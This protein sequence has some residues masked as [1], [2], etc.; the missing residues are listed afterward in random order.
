MDLLSLEDG[1]TVQILT[2]LVDARNCAT[3]LD[4]EE[5]NG[6]RKHLKRLVEKLPSGTPEYRVLYV[7]NVAH[8]SER[9]P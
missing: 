4:L 7:L 3:A 2:I 6:C 8:D 5:S 1:Q 9:S